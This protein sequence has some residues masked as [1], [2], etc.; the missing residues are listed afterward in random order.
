MPRSL[1]LVALL[2]MLG[3][4]T[5]AA[6]LGA[7]EPV[8]AAFFERKVRPLLAAHCLACHDARK[9][10]GGLQLTSRPAALKGGDTGPAVVPGNPNASLLIKAVTYKDPDLQMPPKGDKLSD[11]EIATLTEWVKMGAPDPRAAPASGSPKAATAL[12]LDAA[13]QWWAFRPLARTA[14]PPAKQVASGRQYRF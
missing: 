2:V 4:L 7:A 9:Q 11:A 3:T 14:A 5:G 8:D 13:R 10:K 12:D 1:A 6:R